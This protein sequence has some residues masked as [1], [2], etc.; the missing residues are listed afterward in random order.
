[1]NPLDLTAI[2]THRPAEFC[3]FLS[4]SGISLDF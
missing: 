2:K 1:L 4:L 3:P